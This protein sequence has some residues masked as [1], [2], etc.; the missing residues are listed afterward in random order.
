MS[1]SNTVRKRNIGYTKK[2]ILATTVESLQG[3]FI[4]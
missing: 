2:E 4:F 1:E 3:I